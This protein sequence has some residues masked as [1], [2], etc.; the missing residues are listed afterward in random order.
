METMSKKPM[1]DKEVYSAGSDFQHEHDEMVLGAPTSY[2]FTHDPKHVS[3]VLAR[4]KFVAKMLE[5]KKRV[6]EVGSGDGIGLPL[7]AKVVGHVTCLDWDERHIKSITKRL[8]KYYPNVELHHHDLNERPFDTKVDAIYTVDVIEHLDPAK[9][10]RF[11]EHMLSSLDDD[12]VMITGTPNLTAAEYA[13]PCSA[14]QHIN[15][16]GMKGLREL[17]DKY[18]KHV[19]MFGMNDEVVHTG[20]S[21]MCHYIWSVAAGVKCR[22]A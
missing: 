11:M 14:V 9:E 2:S 21:P 17:M 6:M 19:F 7:V 16:K 15:L 13:S 20:Y 3:F 4:Y 5:G 12:G 10:Q 18:F 8:L 1:T 22:K